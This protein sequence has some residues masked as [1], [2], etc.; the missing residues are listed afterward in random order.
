M[1]ILKVQVLNYKSFRDSGWMEFR[2]GINIITGQNS[3][4]KTALL[5]ALTLEFNDTPHKSLSTLPTKS[6]LLKPESQVHFSL[7]LKDIEFEEI[8]VQLPVPYIIPNSIGGEG[9][10]ISP[11]QAWLVN[12]KQQTLSTSVSGQLNFFC[13]GNNDKPSFDLYETEPIV[14]GGCSHS[15][16]I[17]DPT[18]AGDWTIGAYY[19]LLTLSQN[20]FTAFLKISQKRIYRFLA[21][22]L[23]VGSCSRSYNSE[24]LTN[25]SNLPEVLGILQGNNP[26]LFKIFNHYV[27]IIF[28]QI[29]QISISQG[30]AIEIKVWHIAPSTMRDDLS[31][32][33]SACGT[34]IGQVLSILFVVLTANHPRIIIIDEPQSFLHPGAAKKLIEILKELGKDERFQEHQYIISTH[35][36]TIIAAA[37]PAT[38]TMLKYTDDCETKVFTMD[39]K[40]TRELRYLLDEVGVRLSDVFGMDKILWVE[41]PTEEKC[42]PQ[43][44]TKI[45]NKSMR[46]IQILGVK[47]TG[48]LEGRRAH[49][50]FDVYD[51]LSGSH[52]LFPPAIG[53]IFDRE[54]RTEQEMEDLRKRS[55]NPVKFLPRR[56]YENY[57]LDSDAIASVVNELDEGQEKI[58]TV[59]DVD[60]ILEE[61]KKANC[62]KDS[63]DGSLIDGAN[64]LKDI[65]LKLTESRVEFSKTRDSVKLTEWLIANKP[66]SLKEISDILAKLFTET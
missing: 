30:I 22:R 11:F 54:K 4:G 1:L 33:L 8:A 31:F 64:T 15:Q 3:A 32:P 50:I 52:N 48:D 65:F 59:S 63:P 21:E 24:L 39:S 16:I 47:N 53:F 35:S 18:Q 38:I 37:E 36:P 12:P 25:A 26:E 27:S 2:T 7:H 23:N 45:L 62:K 29:K 14:N 61:C 19:S 44:I 56:M 57:L 13:N 10:A 51:K 17:P 58:I 66:E 41:G 49:I 5:E 42:Y 28:P 43:I 60:A 46:G 40:D 34:G 55:S 20:S 6:S 9:K